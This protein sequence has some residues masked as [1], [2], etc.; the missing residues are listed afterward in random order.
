MLK[1]GVFIEPVLFLAFSNKEDAVIASNQH[2]CLCRNEDIL[3]PDD[4][5]IEV[6]TDDF[7]ANT[8]EYA[9]FELVF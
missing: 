2:I 8:D 3:Y 9:G 5:I 7:N 4:E 6:S 1:R